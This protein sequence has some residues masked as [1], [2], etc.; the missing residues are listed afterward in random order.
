MF[1]NTLDNKRYYTLNCFYR[2]KFKSKVFKVPLD[3]H[4]SCPNRINGNG[5]IFC[6]DHSKA[7][8]IDSNSSLL[9]QFNKNVELLLKKWPNSLYIPYFQAGTNTYDNVENLKEMYEQFLELPGVVGI[10][11]AT[12]PDC[13]SN[14]VIDYLEELN[15]KTFLTIELGLQTSNDNTLKFINRGHDTDCFIKAVQKLRSKN[16]FV[17]A[18]IINGLPY[19]TEEDMLN[20]VKLLNELN[21]NG[22]KIHMLY[23]SKNTELAKI[24][25]KNKFPILRKEEYIDIVIKQLELL[26]EN[27]VIERITGD[28]IKD[29][30]I[31]PDWLLKKFCVL[32]DIDKEMVRRDT[33]QGVK[34]NKNVD[35]K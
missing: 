16:I 5:C 14:E 25:E 17:V 20:T 27:I 13:L 15:K 2:N 4:Y 1:K 30:L 12:R 32:N 19:E 23:V 9:E 29:E 31:A 22:I 28:P 24:Y 35:N 21:V 7:N 3:A 33:Y 8:I 34:A 26:D 6:S 11:I 18:H 10:S